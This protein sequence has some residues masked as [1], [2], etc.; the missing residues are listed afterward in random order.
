[1]TAA[2]HFHSTPADRPFHLIDLGGFSIADA[3]GNFS[4]GKRNSSDKPLHMDL[5]WSRPVSDK[6]RIMNKRRSSFTVSRATPTINHHVGDLR[7]PTV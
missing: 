4:G 7:R 3:T 6:K 5:G 2:G 1:M